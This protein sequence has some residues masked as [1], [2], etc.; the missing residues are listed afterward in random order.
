MKD[1]LV[2]TCI[3]SLAFRGKN[4]RDQDVTKV[5]TDLID[6]GQVKIIGP[7]R[8]E[9]LSGYSDHERYVKLRDR[10]AYFPDVAVIDSDYLLA[11]ELSNTCR[12]KGIQGSHTDFLICSVAIRLKLEIYTT[13]KDFQYYA[14]YLPIALFSSN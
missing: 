1:I 12:I 2:D 10:L 11:A 5:L 13:D 6:F 8:Q 7:I 9:I 14:E 3:W 4:P